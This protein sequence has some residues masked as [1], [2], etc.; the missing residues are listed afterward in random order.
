[1]LARFARTA[2][3]PALWRAPRAALSYPAHEVV[4]LPA[5]SPTMEMGTIAAWKVDEGGAF[6]AGDVIAE[7]ETDKA[8]VDFEAQDDGVLA[9]ILVQAG[10]EVAAGRRSTMRKVIAKRLTESR[11]YVPH[12]FTTMSADL[13]A[14]GALRKS[15]AADYGVKAPA[16]RRANSSWDGATC[17]PNASV[18]ISVAVATPSG[19]I[20]PIVTDAAGKGLTVISSEACILAVGGG[21]NRVKSDGAGGAAGVTE[22]TLRLS[23]DRRVVDEPTAAQFMQ[24]FAYYIA[25]PKLLVL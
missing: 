6:G 25:H 15:L 1:M 16:T 7:I 17:V 20:T 14:V 3:R 22:M 9:K 21:V 23:S 8:T 10:T 24:A 19:L 18:D 2:A 5:L 13:A 11:A 4:G 12:G